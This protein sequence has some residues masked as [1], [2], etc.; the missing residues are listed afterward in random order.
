MG[1]GGTVNAML[2]SLR[3]NK[4]PKRNPFKN[5]P[6]IRSQTAEGWGKVLKHKSTPQQLKEIRKRLT[7]ENRQIRRNRIIAFI[8]VMVICLSAAVIIF[9]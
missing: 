4:R 2:I 7:E 1:F 8:V 3:N 9:I 5:R 6:E